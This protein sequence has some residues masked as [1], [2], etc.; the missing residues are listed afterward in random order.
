MDAWKRRG[1]IS[2][3]RKTTA[4]TRRNYDT[5]P[6]N[7]LDPVPKHMSALED[8]EIWAFIHGQILCKPIRGKKT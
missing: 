3:R 5:Y 1:T 4:L 6:V 7:L 2:F 8:R